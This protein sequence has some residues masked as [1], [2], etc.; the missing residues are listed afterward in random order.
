MNNIDNFKTLKE[1]EKYRKEIN[2]ACDKRA[3]YINRCVEAS[4]I[5]TKPFVYLKE[6][7]ESISPKLYKTEDGQKILKKYTKII[8]ENKNLSL[9][10]QLCENIRKANKDSDIDFFI[11]SIADKEWTVNRKSLKEDMKKIGRV[12]AEGYIMVGETEDLPKE[13]N[14]FIASVGYISENK[15]TQKNIAEYSDAVKVIREHIEK[16]ETKSNMFESKNLEEV[17]QRLLEDFNKKYSDSLNEEEFKALKEISGSEDR[18]AVFEKYKKDCLSKISEA[19]AQ[20]VANGDTESSNRLSSVME[21][22]SNKKYMLE[23]IGSDICNLIELSNI[24]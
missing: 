18:E 5:S 4:E 17:T 13:D 7:F 16:N 23:T 9:M 14:A 1:I 6:T 24:F 3:K 20:F 19:K 11:N 21:Q 15:K 2:E 22:V 10:H 8:R 12:V